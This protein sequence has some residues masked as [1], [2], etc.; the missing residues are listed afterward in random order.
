MKVSKNSLNVDTLTKANTEN[1]E[2]Q[3]SFSYCL[4]KHSLLEIKVGGKGSAFVALVA[5]SLALLVIVEVVPCD[6]PLLIP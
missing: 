6:L 3:K 5:S 1:E 4:W 2:Y